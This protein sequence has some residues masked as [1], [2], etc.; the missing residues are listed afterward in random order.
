MTGDG[1]APAPSIAVRDVPEQRR[2]EARIAGVDD[3]AVA[4]YRLRDG[5]IVFTHTE[6]PPAF[7]GRGVG[8]RLARFAL[9]DAARRHLAVIPRCPFMATVI[10]RHPQYVALVPDEIRTELNLDGS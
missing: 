10:R 1:A 3:V 5:T 7:A 2:Y 8:M 9:D 6:V 4:N